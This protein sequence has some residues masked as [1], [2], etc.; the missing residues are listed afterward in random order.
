MSIPPPPPPPPPP[1]RHAL[2][3]TFEAAASPPSGRSALLDASALAAA[4]RVGAFVAPA[5]DPSTIAPPPASPL[6]TI[7]INQHLPL[8]LQLNPPNFSQW[9]TLFEVTFKKSGVLAHLS[10]PSRPDDLA[11][12][13]DDAYVVSW[14]YTRMRP[15]IFGLV[16]QRGATAAELW[17]SITSLFL[18]NREHQAVLHTTEFRRLEQGSGPVIS[19]FARPKECAD[20]LADLGEPISDS[21]QV[22]NMFRGLHPRLRYAIPILT[23]Q[24]PFPSFL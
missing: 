1:S 7:Y 20:R 4:N 24:T 19:F 14:L 23:M 5:T 3:G 22:M 9:R 16:H 10:G 15:E 2:S 6:A 8:V 18:E 17:A 12:V 21:E 13:Q 11:W